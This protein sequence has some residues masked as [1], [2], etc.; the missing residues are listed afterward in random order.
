MTS[1]GGLKAVDGLFGV[2]MGTQEASI[3]FTNTNGQVIATGTSKP[4]KFVDGLPFGHKEHNLVD[5]EI[6]FR[7]AFADFGKDLVAK[8]FKCREILGLLVAGQM[9]G[10]VIGYNDGTFESTARLWLGQ[11]SIQTKPKMLR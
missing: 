1:L 11:G 7:Q 8:G 10:L 9:H 6:A 4:I 3:V 2:D 5:W